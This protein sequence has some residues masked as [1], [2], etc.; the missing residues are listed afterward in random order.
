MAAGGGPAAWSPAAGLHQAGQGMAWKAVTGSRRAD[1]VRLKGATPLVTSPLCP[2]TKKRERP[3]AFSFFVCGQGAD[4]GFP[5]ML[6]PALRA[7]FSVF[8]LGQN[9]SS[10]AVRQ[11]RGPAVPA[12]GK[13]FQGGGRAREGGGTVFTK[14]VPPPLVYPVR[15]PGVTSCCRTAATGISHPGQRK[16][17]SGGGRA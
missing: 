9:A 12:R 6:S 14:N 3:K 10:P 11:R 13:F 4:N 5:W 7:C 16:V 15:L 17:F 8:I 2:D 1:S